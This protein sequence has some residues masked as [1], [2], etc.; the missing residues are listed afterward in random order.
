MEQAQAHKTTQGGLQARAEIIMGV[1]C[2]L[3]AV[4]VGQC[5]KDTFVDGRG[6][7]EHNGVG[8]SLWRID[9]HR[10]EVVTRAHRGG[11]VDGLVL[12]VKDLDLQFALVV[13]CTE[14]E[15][16]L[17]AL[18]ELMADHQLLAGFHLAVVVVFT[19]DEPLLNVRRGGLHREGVSII[20]GG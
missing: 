7:A 2:P 4:A 17:V 14:P 10:G 13:G 20:Y 9:P 3:L 18:E 15:G 1:A 8:A 5:P 19:D 16:I 12:L 11:D 6:D